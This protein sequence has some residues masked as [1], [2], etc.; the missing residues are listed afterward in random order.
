MRV[1]VI[2]S[3]GIPASYGG[4]ETLAEQLAYFLPAA[5]LHLTVI[6]EHQTLPG[7]YSKVRVITT[8][9]SKRKFPV[10]FYLESLLRSIINNDVIILLGVGAGPFLWMARI[11]HRKTITN[12]DGLEHLRGKYS[13]LQKWYVLLAQRITAW[14][15]NWLVA[16]SCIVAD[17]WKQKYSGVDNKI[18]VIG[19]G[20]RTG[21][22]TSNTVELLRE[23]G[24]TDNTYYLVIARIVPEN[25]IQM[26]IDGFLQSKS[27][28]TLL[29][30]GNWNDSEYGKLIRERT[31][32]NL[33]FLD[34]VYDNEKTSALRLHCLA[35]LHGHSVGGT[36]PTLVES[37]AA[38]AVTVCH[39]NPFNRETTG[40]IGYFFH[41]ATSLAEAVHQLEQSDKE[42]LLSNKKNAVRLAQEKYDWSSI[43]NAYEK[44]IQMR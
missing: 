33:R 20:A 16:D 26:I 36:N 6:G 4:F 29:I 44:L 8:F 9:F 21:N 22:S 15:S 27:A 19:Y 30:V 24:V 42:L 32:T 12:V 39:D 41:D 38:A 28:F 37:L 25:N 11:F 23:F 34:P 7:N 14:F 35:Y 13:V 3:R 40:N 43:V 17:Y 18:S 1:A 31:A 2:G 10:L 5:D